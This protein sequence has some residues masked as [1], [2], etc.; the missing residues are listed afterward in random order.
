MEPIIQRPGSLN[1]KQTPNPHRQ[2]ITHID[3]AGGK[4]KTVRRKSKARGEKPNGKKPKSL[5]PHV[6]K[7]CH[8]P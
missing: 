1:I 2:P 6:R 7:A 5:K 8:L 4:M 3:M